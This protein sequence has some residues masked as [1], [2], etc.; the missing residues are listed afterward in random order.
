MKATIRISGIFLLDFA[1]QQQVDASQHLKAQGR[2]A[3]FPS[4]FTGRGWTNPRTWEV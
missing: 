3:S 2:A 4:C 1:Y